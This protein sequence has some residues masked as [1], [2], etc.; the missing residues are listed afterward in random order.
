MQPDWMNEEVA[1]QEGEV[2][3]G[4]RLSPFRISR[5]KAGMSGPSI[6]VFAEAKGE[7]ASVFVRVPRDTME[8]WRRLVRGGHSVAI[9]A[10]MELLLDDLEATGEEILIEQA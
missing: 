5:A 8:R 7:T 2:A 6:R 10:G 3:F 4:K 9:A 1:T